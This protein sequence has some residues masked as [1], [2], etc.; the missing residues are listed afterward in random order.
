MAATK[1]WYRSVMALLDL[2]MRL[3]TVRSETPSRSRT[4]AAVWRVSLE[5]GVAEAGR[6]GLE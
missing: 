2:P 1:F 3:M 6:I 5:S 4:T